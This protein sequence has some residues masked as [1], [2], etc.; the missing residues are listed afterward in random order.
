MVNK[1][2]KTI[3]VNKYDYMHYY[4]RCKEVWFLSN[5]I[6]EEKIDNLINLNS[7]F[8]DSLDEKDNSIENERELN[9]NDDEKENTLNGIEPD[10]EK[11]QNQNNQ[12]SQDPKF[13]EGQ[14]VDKKAKDFI[15]SQF[16][17]DVVI[18]YDDKAY[19]KIRFDNELSAKK[20]KEDLIK[21]LRKHQTFI[22]FQPTF[23]CKTPSGSNCVTKCDCLVYKS[24]NECNLIEVKG[25]SSTKLIYLL[26]LLFQKYVIDN[27]DVDLHVN[28]YYLCL[29]G[30]N[31]A[32]KGIIPFILTKYIN[33]SKDGSTIS[34]KKT[35]KLHGDEDKVFD[36]ITDSL[37]IKQKLQE[38]Q[39]QY[40]NEK[41]AC[42]TGENGGYTIDQVL[43]AIF[44][45][46]SE[47]DFFKN[48]MQN[49]CNES[50]AKKLAHNFFSK[51]EKY[52]EL[53]KNFDENIKEIFDQK[54][55]FLQISCNIPK[56]LPCDKCNYKYK[57][58]D[59]QAKCQALFA[60]YYKNKKEFYPY[61]YSGKVFH[62]DE[63]YQIYN[64]I[65]NKVIDF[66]NGVNDTNLKCFKDNVCEK[67]YLP[68]FNSVSD[69]VNEKCIID[70][71]ALR[72]LGDKLFSR[73]KRVYF[74]FESIDPAIV[75]LTGF[76]PLNHVV[77]Q[78]S[79]IKT[80][81]YYVMENPDNML[82]D[83]KDITIDWFKCIIKHLYE[84]DNAWYIVY[85]KAFEANR[86]HEIDMLIA[87]P[88][89]HEKIKNIC[90]NIFD[91]VDFFNTTHFEK[92]L[93]K[94]A[95]LPEKLHG[96]YT[97]KKVINDLIP[98]NILKSVG[99]KHYNDPELSKVH[100]GDAAKDATM[101]R[102]LSLFS[103]EASITDED[104]KETEKALKTYCEN[105]VRAMIAVEKYIKQEFIDK[106]PKQ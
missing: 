74:D 76:I 37:A 96:Y 86:L 103:N 16:Q 38:I 30:C 68:L 59:Y 8:N 10:I 35:I 50:N 77:T 54:K 1:T 80:D 39:N 92:I 91:L 65:A 83:P 18:D 67:K 20:T 6:I 95:I 72:F 70:N 102:Y 53:I 82:R 51:Y 104:W 43:S 106:M 3:C 56:L 17:V 97:I 19:D 11:E 90:D 66:S 81:N 31:H 58:C 99:C 61:L 62:A 55:I 85:N 4:T 23:I 7:K 40:I 13:I 73:P 63:K 36:D 79:I 87:E 34:K 84:G 48:L 47:E 93:D 2:E 45:Q 78:C 26:D 75:P 22:M 71:E 57:K 15:K 98:L 44:N 33:L 89:Y 42:K 64:D 52:Y 88:E 28:N 32:T 60:N 49:G 24:E 9:L 27:A 5:R 25:S 101:L 14:L 12:S 69:I 21:L 29:I 46:S 94:I 41:E 105:D 100:K